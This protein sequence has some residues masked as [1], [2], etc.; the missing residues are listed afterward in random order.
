MWL[1]GISHVDDPLLS[2]GTSIRAFGDDRITSPCSLPRV[3]VYLKRNPALRW[4]FI[5]AFVISL[6]RA[7]CEVRLDPRLF[8]SL[9][10]VQPRPL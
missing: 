6:V 3:L 7:V 8:G 5:L 2:C 1:Y 4:L 10:V 9:L